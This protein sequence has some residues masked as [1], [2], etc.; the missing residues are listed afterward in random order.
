M[1]LNLQDLQSMIQ[2][3]EQM[4]IRV[5]RL[6]SELFHHK[7]NPK[8]ESYSFEFAIPLLQSI[9]TLANVMDID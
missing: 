7:T 1:L 4:G 6:S 2:W 8:V 5:F 9:G 3:N